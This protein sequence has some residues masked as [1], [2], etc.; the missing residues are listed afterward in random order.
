MT[1]FDTEIYPSWLLQ[2]SFQVLKKVLE[3]HHICQPET[4][5]THAQVVKPS[6]NILQSP[7]L[8]IIFWW[9]TLYIQPRKY[10]KTFHLM[11]LNTE[12]FPI[13]T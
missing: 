2:Q 9:D 13:C 5:A 6:L 1:S 3:S 12:Y 11:V 4:I 10:D 7:P 8:M